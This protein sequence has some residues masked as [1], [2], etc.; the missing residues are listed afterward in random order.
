MTV[1]VGPN[2]P[3]LLNLPEYYTDVMPLEL[4]PGRTH[5][6]G[7]WSNMTW[8][9]ELKGH[10]PFFSHYPFLVLEDPGMSFMMRK[11]HAFGWNDYKDGI[12]RVTIWEVRFEPNAHTPADKQPPDT[13]P[14]AQAPP[15]PQGRP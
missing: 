2:V 3:S 13:A 5:A 12:G 6:N 15:K 9:A 10:L 11:E 8:T 1:L 7:Q 14:P 4:Q